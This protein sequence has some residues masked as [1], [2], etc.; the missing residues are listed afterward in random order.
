MP[1]IDVQGFGSVSFPDTMSEDDIK[2]ALAEQFDP[3]W[4]K[5]SGFQ[6]QLKE[7]KRMEAAGIPATA[8][9]PAIRKI[10]G[11]VV[12]GEIGD[13]HP[14]IAD[15]NE[16]TTEN[17][18]MKGFVTPAGR[19]I[20]RPEA[21]QATGVPTEREPGRLHSTDLIREAETPT[22]PEPEP[23]TPSLEPV[24]VAQIPGMFSPKEAS[25]ERTLDLVKELRYGKA[26]PVVP[27]GQEPTPPSYKKFEPG[28]IPQWVVDD[29]MQTDL[30]VLDLAGQIAYGAGA[31]IAKLSREGGGLATDLLVSLP[32]YVGGAREK[33]GPFR[34]FMAAVMDDLGEPLPIEKELASENDWVSWGEAGVVAGG[35]LFGTL[36]GLALTGGLG[37]EAMLPV[38]VGWTELTAAQR[39][40]ALAMGQ[41]LGAAPVFGLDAYAQT[42]DVFAAL[43]SAGL[44]AAFP[45]VEQASGKM[46]AN[47]SNKLLLKGVISEKG[48]KSLESAFNLAGM[49]AMMHG[50]STPEYIDNPGEWQKTF[51]KSTS[52]GLVFSLNHVL[53]ATDPRVRAEGLKQIDSAVAD[54]IKNMRGGF[55]EALKRYSAMDPQDRLKYVQR[56]LEDLEQSFGPRVNR[57]LRPEE[58]RLLDVQKNL[59]ALVGDEALLDQEM[60]RADNKTYRI[61]DYDTG[62]AYSRVE[63]DGSITINRAGFQQHMQSGLKRGVTREEAVRKFVKHEDTHSLIKTME[64]GDDMVATIWNHLPKSA[65]W[66]FGRLYLGPKATWKDIEAEGAK[67]MGHEAVRFLLDSVDSRSD[68]LLQKHPDELIGPRAWSAFANLVLK[69]DAKFGDQGKVA[70]REL[71]LKRLRDNIDTVNAQRKAR[72]D[73]SKVAQATKADGNVPPQ[74]VQGAGQVPVQGSRPGVRTPAQAVAQGAQV[75]LA[76]PPKIS[77]VAKTKKPTVISDKTEGGVRTVVLQTATGQQT[78]QGNP[79]AIGKV[80]AKAETAPVEAENKQI[81][82]H[83][84]KAGWFIDQGEEK[85][86]AWGYDPVTDADGNIIAVFDDAGKE[87]FNREKILQD[88]KAKVPPVKGPQEAQPKTPSAVSAVTGAAAPGEPAITETKPKVEPVKQVTEK[89]SLIERKRAL[90]QTIRARELTEAEEAEYDK[91]NARLR[92]IEKAG[93]GARSR[94]Q[95]IADELGV[96]YVGS[97]FGRD[98]YAATRPDERGMSQVDFMV[99]EG[100]ERDVVAAK[101]AERMKSYGPGARSRGMEKLGRTPE[102]V[103]SK[104][105]SLVV[106]EHLVTIERKGELHVGTTDPDKIWDFGP[107]KKIPSIAVLSTTGPEDRPLWSHGMLGKEDR[108]IE[109]G[110]RSG[111]EQLAKENAARPGAR[112]RT[113]WREY[114]YEHPDGWSAV[115][116]QTTTTAKGAFG[117]TPGAWRVSY[118]DP[119]MNPRGHRSFATEEEARAGVGNVLEGS[120]IPSE[121]W[122]SMEPTIEPDQP[123]PEMPDWG[124]RRLLTKVRKEIFEPRQLGKR[125]ASQGKAITDNPYLEDSPQAKSWEDGWLDHRE[126]N[127]GARSRFIGDMTNDELVDYGNKLLPLLGSQ[128][129]VVQYLKDQLAEEEAAIQREQEITQAAEE[130]AQ[131]IL[132]PLRRQEGELLPIVE[133]VEKSM[134]D[135]LAGPITGKALTE[136]AL[137]KE[138]E[139]RVDYDRPSFRQWYAQAN[140]LMA[141]KMDRDTALMMWEESVWKHLLNCSNERLM[142]W[143]KGLKL[144]RKFGDDKTRPIVRPKTDKQLKEELAADIRRA[145]SAGDE[146]AKVDAKR[147]YRQGMDMRQRMNRYLDRLISEMTLKLTAEGQQKYTAESIVRFSRPGGQTSIAEWDIDFEKHKESL[148]P[149]LE[150]TGREDHDELRKCLVDLA[151]VDKWTTRTITKRV[152]VLQNKSTKSIDIV[153]TYQH[154]ETKKVM[155]YSPYG[156]IPTGRETAP[157]VRPATGEV[158]EV[159]GR[160][161]VEEQLR[162]PTPQ[163]GQVRRYLGAKKLYHPLEAV[164]EHYDVIASILLIDPVKE[165]HIRID[166]TE[167]KSAR[168]IYD[169]MV[170]SDAA[171]HGKSI[172]EQVW[173]QYVKTREKLREAAKVAQEQAR[174]EEEQAKEEREA[175]EE[176]PLAKRVERLRAGEHL[177]TLRE[178]REAPGIYEEEGWEGGGVTGERADILRAELGLSR[179]VFKKFSGSPLAQHEAAGLIRFLA[180]YDPKTP[181]EFRDA[182]QKLSKWARG[183]WPDG[184]RHG[185]TAWERCAQSA[186]DKIARK[187]YIRLRRDPETR[188][189]LKAIKDDNARQQYLE[190]VRVDAFREAT[191]KV[192][193]IAKNNVE[194]GPQG[195]KGYGVG[196]IRELLEGYGD[197]TQRTIAEGTPVP[198]KPAIESGARTLLLTPRM[199]RGVPRERHV[200]PPR[201]RPVLARPVEAALPGGAVPEGPQ[202][203]PRLPETRPWPSAVGREVPTR[204]IRAVP[205]L[206]RPQ[207]GAAPP[208]EIRGAP[209][210]TVTTPGEFL[211]RTSEAQ[212]G[213]RVFRGQPSA[214][215]E[216]TIGGKPVKGPPGY[217]LGRPQGRP[218]EEGPG[219]R[220]RYGMSR[221]LMEE[222][223]EKGVGEAPLP[224]IGLSAVDAERL[225][226]DARKRYETIPEDARGSLVNDIFFEN[227]QRES[228]PTV[229]QQALLYVH[230]EML[231]SKVDNILEGSKFGQELGTVA[232]YVPDPLKDPFTSREFKAAD[233]ALRDFRV[234]MAGLGTTLSNMFKMR[235]LITTD[236]DVGTVYAMW[237]SWKDITGEEPSAEMRKEMKKRVDRV[238]GQQA[239]VRRVAEEGEEAM[240]DL[241]DEETKPSPQIASLMESV[242]AYCDQVEAEALDWLRKNPGTGALPVEHLARYAQLGAVRMIRMSAKGAVRLDQWRKQMLS[243]FGDKIKDDIDEIETRALQFRDKILREQTRQ[244]PRAVAAEVKRAG[245]KR[246]EAPVAGEIL[247]NEVGAWESNAKRT[248]SY[249]VPPQLARRVWTHVKKQYIEDL[250][251]ESL[252][253][254]R[255]KLATELGTSRDN[256][257]RILAANKTMRKISDK[258]YYE[259]YVRRRIVDE[260]KNWLKSQA[261]PKWYRLLRGMPRAFFAAKVFGHGLVGMVTH[262]AINMFDYKSWSTY[263]YDFKK[264]KPGGWVEMYM[265]TFSSKY[266]ARRMMELVHD[267]LYVTAR[268]AGLQ[269][270]PFKFTDDYQVLTLARFL[271]HFMGGRGFDALKTLRQARFNQCWSETAPELRTPEMAQHWANDINHATGIVKTVFPEQMNWTFFAPKLEFSRWAWYA[272]LIKAIRYLSPGHKSTPEQEYWAKAK[273]QSFGRIVGMYATLLAMNQGILAAIGSDQKVNVDDPSRSDFLA[274]KV[275]GY[276]V[277]VVGPMIGLLRLFAVGLHAMVGKRK[278]YERRLDRAGQLWTDVGRYVRGKFSPFMS[279]AFSAMVQSDYLRR[280]MPWSDERVPPSLRRRGIGRYSYP[281]WM[282]SVVAPIPLEEIGPETIKAIREVWK[283]QG[284]TNKQADTWLNTLIGAGGLATSDPRWWQAVASQEKFRR[285]VPS[286]AIMSA[287]GARVIEDRFKRRPVYSPFIDTKKTAPEQTALE[288]FMGKR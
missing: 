193:E 198:E 154:P 246:E 41:R 80:L 128:E 137:A 13:T 173:L 270:N 16:L 203:P 117:E 274:F 255:D 283:E 94:T 213:R 280:P 222:A 158:L 34:N 26:H 207:F 95:E 40:A 276:N 236:V 266:H 185:V 121:G 12:P 271:N 28:D 197:L 55:G 237:R 46:A 73:A 153:S 66:L 5:Q 177:A 168:Q 79:A 162:P 85:L 144:E 78:M 67:N 3:I 32:R 82:K 107:D 42:K 250:G 86:R 176:E 108:I 257:N 138:G 24:A 48:A 230:G 31:P 112:S 96:R 119:Q 181:R 100:S 111:A 268:R 60:A 265:M 125:D 146:T 214:A 204:G 70:T 211:R 30:P 221:A 44:G 133:A 169:T 151:P 247:R 141:G 120:G 196:L 57:T 49:Q 103:M 157:V 91:V 233:R 59:Q 227:D 45:M 68:E 142:E 134:D 84:E 89:D 101:L 147:L 53:K 150:F 113:N 152:T 39:A 186:I 87:V 104:L 210:R 216:A 118:F 136:K 172:N 184:T 164:Q 56:H 76:V 23:P 25:R 231:Q 178:A 6:A 140:R 254:I 148:G 69:L 256:V 50:L 243:E 191:N 93:P 189:D 240:A 249:K 281:E 251:F 199:I 263:I 182:F 130:R 180:W 192:L 273:M 272:D 149:Y 77:E 156:E 35:R 110:G 71:L 232:K 165:M 135:Y 36:S 238:K 163:E 170:G 115:V 267:D 143:R 279:T 129:R 259:M 72:E 97:Q 20:G 15:R 90:Q 54:M 127:P 33:G 159:T 29:L 75:S 187:E 183:H 139:A 81:R 288:R 161:A 269:N 264:G 145:E 174:Y 7:Y 122:K 262:A 229:E 245:G 124:R 228:I 252:L 160:S 74:S 63:D 8:L 43:E 132:A 206:A 241:E 123:V 195:E 188:K 226:D 19:F 200:A 234:R 27:A 179:S 18:D 38:G 219:A 1:D 98:M 102:E 277:G 275:A 253:E 242:I 155:L 47:L 4:G 208:M 17:I 61:G 106:G 194:T 258:M 83:S 167:G 114:A 260:A 278:P 217:A 116:T 10:G 215:F 58:Y 64:G 202:L 190:G 209:P 224:G 284:M 285:T 244:M 21:A 282:G 11:D 201:G 239:K 225:I 92:E 14:E 9:R 126:S 109:D 166:P 52:Q 218:V 99:P 220:S 105:P 171:A 175:E 2:N 51:V 37:A 131:V 223:A 286:A 235:Q 261:Y 88:I 287:T 212:A 22:T 205:G 248:G 65:Q 62:G